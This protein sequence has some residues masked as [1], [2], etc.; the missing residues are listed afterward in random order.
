MLPKE[1]I[2]FDNCAMLPFVGTFGRVERE[3]AAAY[4]VLACQDRNTW[5]PVLPIEVGEAAKR[6]K[7]R[8][9]WLQNSFYLPDIRDLVE[10]G[11]AECV[12]PDEE[13]WKRPIRFTSLGLE[14]IKSRKIR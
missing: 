14:R 13:G 9:I 2:D 5:D 12:G 3:A 10:K 1:A 6:H 4:L 11:F 7:D 8:L